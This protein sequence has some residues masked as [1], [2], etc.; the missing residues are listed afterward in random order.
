MTISS[1]LRITLAQINLDRACQQLPPL[2][3]R[4]VAEES[5][6]SLSVL[7]ALQMG[8]SHRIDFRTLDRL[9]IYLNQFRP[10]DLNDLLTW[11]QGQTA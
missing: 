1:R 10:T 8:K 9:L 11:S 5:G 3:L 6:V 2:S 4:R 7:A